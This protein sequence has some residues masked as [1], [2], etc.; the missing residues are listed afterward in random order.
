MDRSI[1]GGDLIG[2]W[3]L[4]FADIDFVN[5]KPALTRLGLAAQLKFFASLGFFAIDPGS[6]P[7]DGLSYLAEQLGVEAGEIAGYVN[8]RMLQTVLVEPKWAGR[9]TPEDYRGL[10]PLIYSHVNPY[11][12]F[13]LDLNDRIDFGRL[14]A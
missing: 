9:M 7:T 8:T 1:P 5:S 14:A 12:R 10:T 6:I 11:G 2:R 4:S 3:S 13:D